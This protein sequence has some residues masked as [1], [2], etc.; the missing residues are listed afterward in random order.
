MKGFKLLSNQVPQQLRQS[1]KLGEVLKSLS[2]TSSCFARSPQP[3]YSWLVSLLFFPMQRSLFALRLPA[4]SKAASLGKT[5]PSK[6]DI[7]LLVVIS[8]SWWGLGL[9]FKQGNKLLQ[10]VRHSETPIMRHTKVQGCRSLFDGDWSWAKR[11]GKHPELPSQIA[12]L[13]KQQKGKCHE[14]GLYFAK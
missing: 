2:S 7:G 4:V 5:S 13:L 12:K 3:D 6:P 8:Q 11:M 10:L 1:R 14:C 9:C